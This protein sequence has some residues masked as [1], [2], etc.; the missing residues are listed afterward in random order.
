MYIRK[1]QQQYQVKQIPHSN[2]TMTAQETKCV[3]PKLPVRNMRPTR[4]PTKPNEPPPPPPSNNVLIELS[5]KKQLE[6]I[7]NNLALL[8][9]ESS[10][11]STSSTCSS[12]ASSTSAISSS[13]YQTCLIKTDPISRLIK[14]K[15]SDNTNNTNNNN[16]FLRTPTKG[17]ASSFNLTMLDSLTNS[18]NSISQSSSNMSGSTSL[19]SRA[20]KREAQDELIFRPMIK[21]ENGELTKRE[22]IKVKFQLDKSNEN[23]RIVNST[24]I[25]KSP[26]NLI[27][28]YEKDLVSKRLKE[29]LNCSFETRPKQQK[30]DQEAIELTNKNKR[31]KQEI[32]QNSLLFSHLSDL[33]TSNIIIMDDSDDNDDDVYFM[34]D[35][36]MKYDLKNPIITQNTIKTQEEVFK[37]KLSDEENYELK[38]CYVLLEK[39]DNQSIK[40][41]SR[42]PLAKES[43]VKPEELIEN[44]KEPEK[45]PVVGLKKLK[46]KSKTFPQTQI[47]TI[48]NVYADLDAITILSTVRHVNSNQQSNSNYYES[49]NLRSKLR[50]NSSSQVLKSPAVLPSINTAPPSPAELL[51]KYSTGIG[52]TCEMDK[53]FKGSS[54]TVTQCLECETLRKCP[55]SFYDRSIPIETTECIEDESSCWIAK[56]LSNESYLNENSKYMCDQCASKQEAKI[57][58][59]YTQMPNILILHLLSYGITSSDDGN[60]N[61]R[62]LSNR[63]R[64]VNYFDF[65]CKK[66]EQFAQVVTNGDGDVFKS[67]VTTRRQLQIKKDSSKESN[68]AFKHQF[69]L[70]A[71]VMH[72]GVSLNSGHYTAFVNYKIISQ[73]ENSTIY[74]KNLYKIIKNYF[75]QSFDLKFYSIDLILRNKFNLNIYKLNKIYFNHLLSY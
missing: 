39:L 68:E 7:L 66:D 2:E 30:I 57:H 37:E 36:E 61:T 21:S 25:K 52:Y 67:P 60:L 54:I 65:V 38:D 48:Q 34:D 10:S 3:E 45:A 11:S 28:D 59:Q 55:E 73:R 13:T 16:N 20:N 32:K 43:E 70:F 17:G 44:N 63:L 31:F 35:D 50:S 53:L 64:L 69:R 49:N 58:T 41:F 46:S 1:I 18:K 51:R 42:P 40:S 19:P 29:T 24:A 27:I 12:S 14:A 74:G 26:N 22:P 4:K 6:P 56:C 75:F 47:E 8:T 23:Y 9:D 33:D 5:D 71:V 15:S 72:S 62:K